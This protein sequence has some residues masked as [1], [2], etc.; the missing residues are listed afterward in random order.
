MPVDTEVPS[1]ELAPS[2]RNVI[3]L[4]G[5]GMGEAQRKAAQ[6][7]SKG[8]S[9]ELIMDSL[10]VYGWARTA[11]LDSLITDS[12]ASGTALATGNKTYK[13]RVAVDPDGNPLKTILEYAQE[14]GKSVGLITTVFLSDATPASFASHV[15]DRM[16]MRNEIAAMI[17]EHEVDVLLGGGEDDFLPTSVEGCFPELGHR[18]DGRNLIDEAI[19]LGYTYLC[20]ATA[21]TKINTDRDSKVLGLFGDEEMDRPYAPT[22]AEMT[23]VA[24]EILSK[25]PNGF[26]LMVEGGR[27]DWAC[28]ANNA[29][30]AMDDTLGFDEAVSEAIDFAESDGETL[31]I[32]TADHETGGMSVDLTSTGKPGEDGPFSMPDGKPFYVN[33]TTDYHSAADVPVTAMGPGAEELSGS[34]E[35]THIFEVMYSVLFPEPSDVVVTEQGEGSS[36]PAD[37]AVDLTSILTDAQE[38]FHDDLSI[39]TE[40]WYFHANAQ[41]VDGMVTLSSEGSW[42]SYWT[43]NYELREGRAQLILF[44]FDP[45]ADFIL[46]H[47]ISEFGQPDYFFW[48]INEDSSG[49]MVKGPQHDYFPLEGG[50]VLDP[51]NWY[52]ALFAIGED[53][54]FLIRIWEPQ[55]P[56]N[57]AEGR[58]QFGD[59]WIDRGWWFTFS[60]G[61][62]EVT[63]D[64]YYSYGF[65]GYP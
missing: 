28:H 64:E 13:N 59:E 36:I 31:L 16:E 35:N 27:I 42:D 20:D 44:R 47:K 6:W 60:L 57:W 15:P 8:M 1:V 11:S 2:A 39:L 32:V 17:L 63:I 18:E 58:R 53:A 26:F 62:G 49:F 19:A 12:P 45:A 21:L 25:N 65:S 48:G 46:G 14:H 4:I 61:A 43:N 51:D 24:I 33:W 54:D 38:V 22:L 29:Q 56:A 9:E 52:V 41:V 7:I 40:G 50:L 10:P 55:N 30:T 23:R 37:F 5:D 3:L 34:Y